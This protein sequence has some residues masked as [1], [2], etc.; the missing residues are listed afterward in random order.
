[1]PLSSLPLSLAFVECAVPAAF[2]AF[3]VEEPGAPALDPD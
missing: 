2:M 3:A 1:M